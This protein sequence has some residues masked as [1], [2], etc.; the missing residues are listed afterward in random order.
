MVTRFYSP[1]REHYSCI[2]R[3][4][5]YTTRDPV[6]HAEAEL[7]ARAEVG[8]PPAVHLAVLD[9]PAAATDGLLRECRFAGDVEVLGPVDLPVGV[10]RPAGVDAQLEVV[11]MLVRVPRGQGLALAAA[12]RRAT[13]V[14]SARRENVP[15][16]VQID[17]LHIG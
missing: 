3:T 2:E 7:D 16:R 12:L 17:P 9:G 6:G 10:R 11:R 14:L 8:L 4:W 5:I 15:V 13:A 1:Q